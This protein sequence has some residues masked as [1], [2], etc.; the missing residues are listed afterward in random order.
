VAVEVDDRPALLAAAYVHDIG[1][2]PELVRTGLHAL[3]GGLW[4]REQGP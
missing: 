2:A 4:L 3:D 1:Y